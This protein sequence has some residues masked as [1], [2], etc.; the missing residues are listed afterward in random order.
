MRP[1]ANDNAAAVPTIGHGL[2]SGTCQ[3]CV[4]AASVAMLLHPFGLSGYQTTSLLNLLSISTGHSL[5]GLTSFASMRFAASFS[6]AL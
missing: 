6:T 2:G 1:K 4:V 3:G 5:L